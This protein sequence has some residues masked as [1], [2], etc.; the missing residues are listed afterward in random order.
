VGNLV[1]DRIEQ[2]LSGVD[3]Q[4]GQGQVEFGVTEITDLLPSEIPL[5]RTEGENV[6]DLGTVKNVRIHP[7]SSAGTF[8][9]ELE[10]DD[11]FDG[12]VNGPVRLTVRPS[13]QN[14][15]L[16][17]EVQEATIKAFGVLN[18]DVMQIADAAEAVPGLQLLTGDVRGDLNKN[19]TRAISAVNEA[20][21]N[22]GGQLR[23]VSVH[24]NGIQIS[25][26]TTK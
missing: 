7:D 16:Q 12:K 10:A 25:L 22:M 13:V 3:P 19:V 1:K 2:T 5:T 24:P 20:I 11:V 15:Q 9:L 17:L 4:T 23:D 6:V 14:G 18:V 8:T 26:S 21:S